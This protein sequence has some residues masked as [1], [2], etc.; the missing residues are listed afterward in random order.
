MK[1]T[2]AGPKIRVDE[3]FCVK[4]VKSRSRKT[5]YLQNAKRRRHAAFWKKDEMEM[6]NCRLKV[7]C[8]NL[9]FL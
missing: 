2:L 9:N 3:Y 6:K 4:V 1:N 7:K 8:R 5:P